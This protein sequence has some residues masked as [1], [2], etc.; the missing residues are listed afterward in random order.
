VSAAAQ[1]AMLAR[2]YW[3]RH[4]TGF[5]L[6][7]GLQAQPTREGALKRGFY[8]VDC[9]SLDAPEYIPTGSIRAQ[10]LLSR[11]QQTLY[12][13]ELADDSR[14]RMAEQAERWND[15]PYEDA[16]WGDEHGDMGLVS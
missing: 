4:N 3:F 12:V 14:E 13:T 5:T 6:T 15:D 8:I 9:E 2:V 11:D 16:Y 1:A 7:G 10:E